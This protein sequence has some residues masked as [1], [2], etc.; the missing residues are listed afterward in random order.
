MGFRAD[1]GGSGSGGTAAPREAVEPMAAAA[2]AA[3]AMAAVTGGGAAG[4]G[5]VPSVVSWFPVPSEPSVG[6]KSGSAK[7]STDASPASVYSGRVALGS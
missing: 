4:G 5:S 7:S 1:G 2:V 3:A 6:S